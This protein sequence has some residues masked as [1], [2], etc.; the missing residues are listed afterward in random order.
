VVNR[1][2]VENTGLEGICHLGEGADGLISEIKK[3][4]EKPFSEPDLQARR[5]VLNELFN[6]KNGAEKILSLLEEKSL[7]T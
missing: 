7:Y 3:C 6:N 5:M 4:T 1:E 2:M